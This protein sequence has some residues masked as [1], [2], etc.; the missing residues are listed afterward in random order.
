M[1]FGHY[2]GTDA[3]VG[4]FL[5]ASDQYTTTGVTGNYPGGFTVLRTNGTFD[6]PTTVINSDQIGE[7]ALGVLR[8]QLIVG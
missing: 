6:T 2:N 3:G 7:F 1:S 5:T 8:G 4:A